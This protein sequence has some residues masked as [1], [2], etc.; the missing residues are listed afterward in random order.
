MRKLLRAVAASLLLCVLP[1]ATAVAP[2][3]QGGVIKPRTMYEDLQM[4]SGVLNQIRQNHPDS[5]DSHE[6]IMAAIDGM[7][8]AADPHSYVVE[9]VRF[10]PER[11]KL[12][13]EGKLYPVPIAWLFV[14]GAPVVASVAPG[15]AAARADILPGD[16][17][18]AIDGKPVPS[19]SEME[20][21]LLL[22]GAKGSEV[23]LAFER[24][25]ADGSLVRLERAVKRQKVEE[26]SAV[27]AAFMLDAETGYARIITFATSRAADDL[28]DALGA[29]EKRGMKRLVLDLRDNGGGSVSEAAQVAGEFLP[30]GAIVYTAAGRKADVADTGRVGRSFW[31]SER[32][33]PIV[34]MVNSGTASASELVA[35]ALQDHDRALIVGRTSFGKSLLMFGMPLADGSLVYMVVGHVKTPC[36]RVVQR[37][38]RGLTPHEYRRRA[39]A[40]VD[41]AGRPKCRTAG[42]RTVYGGG[43]IVPDV[44]LPE[45]APTPVWLSRVREADLP[46]K[47]I[48]G[49]VSASGAAYPSLDALAEAARRGP[50]AAPGAVADFRRYAEQQGIAIPADADAD[51]RLDRLIVLSVARAKWNDEGAYRIAAVID[52][53]VA[54]AVEAFGRAREILK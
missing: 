6:L 48:A 44:V 8:R 24:R 36:G 35:G 37:Q 17:L 22:A 15:T 28:H 13:R 4:F 32:R 51:R 10:S 23:T 54:A 27:P 34:V 29:L 3:Q 49:H 33:Y 5:V 42:G 20:L 11:E 40:A 21:D 31:R 46:L 16:E 25:R 12:M 14:E 45:R 30:K 52:S 7:L 9:S 26:E 18:L 2:G 43:G 1:A 39:G 19:R 41:T 38:Y 50:A 53:E 47:W